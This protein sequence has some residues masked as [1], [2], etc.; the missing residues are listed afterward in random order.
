[1]CL[2]SAQ[3]LSDRRRHPVGLDAKFGQDDLR[4]VVTGQASYVAARMAARSTQVETW[5]MTAVSARAR[6]WPIV[7]N[8]TVGE[9]ADQE[10]ALAHVGQS[11]FDVEWRARETVNHRIGEIGRMLLP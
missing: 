7:A 2:Y 6:E 9:S 11:S 5:Q 8:L 10:I 1:L 3:L 4:R